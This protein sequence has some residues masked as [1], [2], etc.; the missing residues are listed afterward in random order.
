M[1]VQ[2]RVAVVRK[3]ALGRIVSRDASK[4]ELQ[5]A[6][7]HVVRLHAKRWHAHVVR[8]VHTLLVRRSS[9]AEACAC[10]V[11]LV[12]QLV[13]DIWRVQHKD[14]SCWERK[15]GANLCRSDHRQ[16][17]QTLPRAR[18]PPDTGHACSFGGHA[19]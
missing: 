18:M 12:Q 14:R 6:L 19:V 13:A 17:K 1:H 8:K 2:S 4:R 7:P 5:H 15:K 16:S 3:H 9:E 11:A 10:P